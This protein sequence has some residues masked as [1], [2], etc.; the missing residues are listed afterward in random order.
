MMDGQ[1]KKSIAVIVRDA[2]QTEIWANEAKFINIL[3]G[4]FVRTMDA[5]IHTS[6]IVGVVKLK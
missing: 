1:H 6:Y 5:I 3:I 2:L 4:I